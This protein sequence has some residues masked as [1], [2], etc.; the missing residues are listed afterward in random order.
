MINTDP[1][2]VRQEIEAIQPHLSL[3]KACG[4]KIMVFAETSGTVHGQRDVPVTKRP[5][6]AESEWPI[7]VERLSELG[8]WMAAQG[9]SIAFHHHMGTVIEKASEIHR[10]MEGTPDSVGL[11]FDTGHLAFAGDRPAAVA[12]KRARRINHVVPGTSAPIL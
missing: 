2:A 10:L 8:E 7:F 11:L 3:L 5:V 4:C 9:V 1:M 6:L 12:R